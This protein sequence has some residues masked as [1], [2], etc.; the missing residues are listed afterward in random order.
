M[1][2]VAKHLNELKRQHERLVRTHE[3]RSSLD[4]GANSD[5]VGFG[6]LVLEVDNLIYIWHCL[7][8]SLYSGW[9][10]GTVV[11]CWSLTG[12]LSLSRTR[13]AADG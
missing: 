8:V 9:S 10:C 2:D 7:C 6:E 12:E 3:L 5:V 11:E 1:M 4:S 13:P